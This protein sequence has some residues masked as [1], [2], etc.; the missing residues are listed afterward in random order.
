MSPSL[1]FDVGA[2]Y[3]W[4]KDGSIAQIGTNATSIATY[5][6]LNGNYSNSVVVVSGQVTWSF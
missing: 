6:Y 5:G 3:I 1:K 2:T 4:V